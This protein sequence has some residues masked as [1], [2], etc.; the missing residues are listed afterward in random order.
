[1]LHLTQL[2]NICLPVKRTAF[3]PVKDR[4]WNNSNKSLLASV[5]VRRQLRMPWDNFI[6]EAPSDL[7]LSAHEA[8][9]LRSLPSLAFNSPSVR[10]S[11]EVTAFAFAGHLG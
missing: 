7:D 2:P 3:K 9:L 11:R 10:Q 4:K 8:E 1:M 6:A 5:P